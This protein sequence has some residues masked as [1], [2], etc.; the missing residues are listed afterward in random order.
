MV[1]KLSTAIYLLVRLLQKLIAEWFQKRNYCVHIFGTKASDVYDVSL[2]VPTG[3]EGVVTDVQLI[4][5]RLYMDDD[6]IKAYTESERKEV[7]RSFKIECDLWMEKVKRNFPIGNAK[8]TYSISIQ[9][10]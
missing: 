10:L 5:R 7:L 8:F 1:Q 2:R 9:K 6:E 3:V 4:S